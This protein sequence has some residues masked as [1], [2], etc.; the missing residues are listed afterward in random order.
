MTHA[1]AED[2]SQR[3]VSSKDIIEID[4]ETHGWM[5]RADCITFHDDAVST[6]FRDV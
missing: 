5:N 2:Q 6:K 1:H 4:G 3:S